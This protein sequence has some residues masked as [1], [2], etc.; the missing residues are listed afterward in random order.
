MEILKK[1]FIKFFGKIE[2]LLVNNIDMK[3][4]VVRLTE[5]DLIRIVKKV[6]SEQSYKWSKPQ[7]SSDECVEYTKIA[8]KKYCK[9]RDKVT[10][11]YLDPVP[12]ESQ[13][14][15]ELSKLVN[16]FILNPNSMGNFEEVVRKEGFDLSN[17]EY[18]YIDRFRKWVTGEVE[19][20]NAELKK[21]RP[22]LKPEKYNIKNYYQ[23]INVIMKGLEGLKTT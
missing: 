23:V 11:V 10:M 8:G 7:S 5:E 14:F 20:M 15:P 1:L 17:R 3:K 16:Y 2:Y 6:V 22:V 19:K 9:K 18:R 4:K 13:E 21:D 12:I